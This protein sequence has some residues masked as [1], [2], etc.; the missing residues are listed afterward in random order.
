MEKAILISEESFNVLIEKLEKLE[1]KVDTINKEC[2][3]E[4]WLTIDETCAFLKVSKR[5]LQ[6]YR[7]KGI[8]PFSQIGSKIY[9]DLKDLKVYMQ[10]YYNQV[11]S[12][13]S[14]FN[15]K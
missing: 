12:S 6:S 3:T 10:R 13:K 4:Q 5:T 9:F 14:V 7:D 1:K 11:F 15:T 2:S 8:L